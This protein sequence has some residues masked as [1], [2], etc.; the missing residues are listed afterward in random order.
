MA[1]EYPAI[2]AAAGKNLGIAD[3][4]VMAQHEPA[5]V[6]IQPVEKAQQGS[7]SMR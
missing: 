6:E 5:L 1:W 7:M 4:V 2:D 3:R